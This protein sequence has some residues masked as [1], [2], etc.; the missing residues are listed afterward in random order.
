M[1]GNVQPLSP[2]REL[3][4]FCDFLWG[5]ETGYVYLPTKEPEKEGK[6]SWSTYYFKWPEQKAD[7]VKHVLKMSPVKHVHI[8]PALFSK[9]DAE[10][11]FVSGSN[12]LWADFDGSCPNDA[13]FAELGIP[14][15]SLR[16]QSSPGKQHVYWKLSQFHTDIKTIQDLNRAI[17]YATDADFSGW[18]A[19]KVLRPVASINHKKGDPV[20]IL[21]G[22]VS[23]RYSYTDFSNVPVPD[24]TFN[25]I[26]LMSGNIPSPL[27]II[28]RYAFTDR[29]MDLLYKPEVGE[30]FRSTSLV[31]FGHILCEK[32]LDNSEIYSLIRWV[33]ERWK[34]FHGRDDAEKR[35]LSLLNYLRFKHPYKGALEETVESS[36]PQIKLM[37]YRDLITHV[38]TQTYIA[39]PQILSDRGFLYVAARAG[40]GK[41]N[42][43][44][45]M[46]H[47]FIFCRNYLDWEIPEQETRH[48]VVHLQLEMSI[49]E[50]K[51][52]ALKMD[53]QFTE[54]E[55]DILQEHYFINAVNTDL[56]L[57]NPI[58]VAQL[59]QMLD[60][61][62]PSILVLDSASVSFAPALKEDEKLIRISA[63]N[64][65]NLRQQYGF[66]VI[67]VGHAKKG[68]VKADG[69]NAFYGM[70]V[71]EQYI[72]T[73]ILLTPDED[74][75]AELVAV[76]DNETQVVD[77]TYAKKRFGPGVGKTFPLHLKSNPLRFERPV[78]GEIEGPKTPHQRQLKDDDV[79]DAF[80]EA[81][82]NME[83]FGII[84]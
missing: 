78:I 59:G 22:E 69:L 34:K 66:A 68:S 13:E 82:R 71:L 73:A 27:K 32:G 61:Y 43:T 64:L 50:Q 52:V 9:P 21:G 18:N 37:G 63:T 2:S 54:E 23:A 8:A 6:E 25:T 30:G 67:V 74:A 48:R 10:V 70:S 33:D 81:L 15:P 38:D 79:S 7:V 45:E 47:K 31:A 80:S 60:H 76:G 36:E 53:A 77:L 51:D 28:G 24:V 84:D 44:T 29:E 16:I 56:H 35:Y 49:A 46:I 55:R 14:K 5:K 19:N 65:F 72:T 11:E 3:K 12:V 75:T 39:H 4:D 40:V 26:P 17:T 58:H 1:S 83:K 62:R 57:Y 20:V 41:T 42:M